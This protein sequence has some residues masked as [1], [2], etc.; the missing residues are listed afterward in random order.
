MSEE[1]SPEYYRKKF[2]PLIYMVGGILIAGTIILVQHREN[3]QRLLQGNE[4]KLGQTSE[5]LENR[6]ATLREER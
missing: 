3:I 4:R 6:P 5:P 2:I 1:H